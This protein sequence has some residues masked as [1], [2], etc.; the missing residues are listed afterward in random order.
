M[1]RNGSVSAYFTVEAALVMPIVLGCYL[2]VILFLMY[3][4]ERCIWETNAY[5]FN[6]W[7][8]YVE[9][10]AASDPS[11][12]EISEKKI[13]QYLLDCLNREENQKYFLGQNVSTQIVNR[14]EYMN[15][16]RKVYYPQFAD[17]E[18]EMSVSCVHLQPAVYLRSVELIKD[19]G[20]KDNV[21]K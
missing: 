19:L 17:E 9:G 1:K 15:V 4:Y 10:F 12:E 5:R 11:V 7:K 20:R 6:V 16:E 3:I 14:G 13:S 21:S 8:A 2:F 18:Y